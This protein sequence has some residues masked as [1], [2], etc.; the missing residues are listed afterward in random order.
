MEFNMTVAMDNDAFSPDAKDELARI[1][2]TVA[3]KITQGD[4]NGPI[5]DFCGNRVGS[6]N[7]TP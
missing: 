4:I 6:F 7:I 3:T 2:D 5:R 1:L